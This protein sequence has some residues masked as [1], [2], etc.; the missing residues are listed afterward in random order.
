MQYS[1]VTCFAVA[2]QHSLERVLAA[3]TAALIV[4]MFAVYAA[5]SPTEESAFIGG[6][7]RTIRRPDGLRII[8]DSGA[9][10]SA[11]P[12]GR[13]SLITRVTDSNPNSEISIANAKSL[14]IVEI[15]EAGLETDG[16]RLSRTPGTAPSSWPVTTCRVNLPLSRAL[17]VDGL[18]EN[19]ILLSVRGLR[20][21]GIKVFFNDDNSIQRENCLLLSDQETVVPF[22]SGSVSYQ[23]AASHGATGRLLVGTEVTTQRSTKVPRLFHRALGHIGDRRRSHSNVVIDGVHMRDLPEHDPTTCRGCRL[24]NT[25]RSRAAPQREPS[26]SMVQGNSTQGFTHFGQQVESDIC[27]G[28]APS[29]PHMFTSMVN[30]VDRYQH[31][32][33]IFF[34]L[35]GDSSEVCSSLENYVTTNASRL[36]DGKIGIWKCDNSTT[37]LSHE[38]EQAAKYLVDKRKYSVQYEKNS[39]AVPERNWGVLERMMRSFLA[40][41]CDPSDAKPTGAPECLW[42]W[43]AAQANALLYYLPT[44]ALVPPQ[45]PYQKSTGDSSPVDLSWART[46]FCDVTVTLPDRDVVGKLDLRSCDGCHLGYDQRRGAHFV[47]CPSVKRISTF[48]VKEWR[49]DSFT[50]CKLISCDTPVEYF[51]A[52]DLT[53]S[54][55]TATLVPRR[56]TARGAHAAAAATESRRVIAVFHR[57]RPDSLV[58]ILRSHGHTVSSYDIANSAA[59]DLT[60][61]E[62]QHRVLD[63]IRGA[64]FVFLCPPC[65]SANIAVQPPWRTFPDHPCGVPGL[66]PRHQ[67]I[68]DEHN[69]LFSF[70]AEC[71]LQCDA[72]GIP[73]AF[74]SCASRRRDDAAKWPVYKNTAMIY[75]FPSIARIMANTAATYRVT[76]QCAWGAPYQKF[77]GLVTSGGRASTAFDRIFLGGVCRCSSH[78]QVLQGYDE[79]G[80]ACTKAAEEYN[81]AFSAAMSAAI[82]DSFLPKQ[83]GESANCSWETQ[84]RCLSCDE[85]STTAAATLLSSV[86]DPGAPV[87]TG[88]SRAQITELHKLAHR[89]NLDVS[90]DVEIW[91]ENAEGAYRVSEAGSELANIKTVSQ[92]KES[93]FWPLFKKAMEDEIHGK[94]KNGAWSVVSRPTD[95]KVHKSRWVY[96]VKLNDDGSIC[97]VKARFVGCGYSQVQGVEYDSVFAATLP[98]VSFRTLMCC[99]AAE[100]LDTDQLDAVKAF[101]QAE[102]DKLVYVEMPEGFEVPGHVCLLHMALEGIKQGAALWF[103]LNRAAWLKLGAKTWMNETNLYLFAGVGIRVGV[104]ADDGITGFPSRARSQWLAIKK[105]YGKIVNIT[106][107]DVISPALKFTGVQIERNRSERK[108]TLHQTRYMEQLEIE[109]EGKFKRQDT[110]FGESKEQRSKFERLGENT[111]SELFD[112]S[113]YLQLM[114]KLVWP[115]SMTRPDVAMSVSLLCSFMAAPRRVHYDAALGVLGY[116]VTTKKLG[117]TY[118]GPLLIPFGLNEKPACF[119]ESGGLH[120]MHD[121]SWGTQPRPMGGYVIMYCNGAIDWSAKQVKIVPDSTCHAETAVASLAAKA[122]CFTRENLR[123]QGRIVH[124]P[125]A[126]IGDNKAMYDNVQKE[127]ATAKTRYYERATLLI[128]RAVLLLI[129][130]P[131]LVSTNYMLADIFTKAPEKAVFVRMRNR[132]MNAHA[133]LRAHLLAMLDSSGAVTGAVGNLS[134]RLLGA[135]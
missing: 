17:V 46:M 99:I 111:S 38:T 132:M 75:D 58:S 120:C 86:E 47:Y 30:F 19:T 42:T 78:K 124:G 35:S 126:M 110:P 64:D 109:Y 97:L 33:A 87:T 63:D 32:S 66:P 59:Q 41:A 36:P 22:L 101:T 81:P 57:D 123:A 105:E 77:T 89:E 60:K 88:L 65:T 84:L 93:K 104:F 116:L 108:I 7:Q 23:I 9:T 56:H 73:W 106:G 98:G 52:A 130:K 18:E 94:M 4:L 43:A 27:V 24:G 26:T 12:I 112:T 118:G 121:S 34:M 83:E 53:F 49:E 13:R 95:R 6:E 25:G 31:E 127:G 21:D 122:T 135:L 28:F 48:V 1:G 125:T 96:A 129:L 5:G 37:F 92:A 20:K 76:A 117:I 79:E 114:G 85:L 69:I 29:F 16:Y 68:V 103:A 62:A 74:E 133:S 119:D 55:R 102:I 61:P 11:I 107:V 90:P 8:V 45:S 50:I 134:R 113:L 80:V 10:S 44:N 15:G 39:L 40:D 67:R 54:P 2:A 51:E 115:S 131:F 14:A 72:L 82:E 71:I 128:K 91:L 100:D 3:G 70:T